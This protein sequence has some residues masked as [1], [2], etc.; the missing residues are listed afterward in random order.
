MKVDQQSSICAPANAGSTY[1]VSL[2]AISV[3]FSFNATTIHLPQR[4][5]TLPQWDLQEADQEWKH[6]DMH[7][8][9]TIVSSLKTL[10]ESG[11]AF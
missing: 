10:T 8:L 7:N 5:N 1:F 4:K 3:F 6:E 2:E 11:A 9:Q